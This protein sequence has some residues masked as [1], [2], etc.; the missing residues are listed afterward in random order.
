MRSGWAPLRP[1][2][3]GSSTIVRPSSGPAARAATSATAASMPAQATAS[4]AT[5]RG[6][7]PQAGVRL[8]GREAQPRRLLVGVADGEQL[9]VAV[10]GAGERDVH[11]VGGLGV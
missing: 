3:P 6:R 5:R 9:R 8:A 1:L 4:A 7:A 10:R 2:W 11:G